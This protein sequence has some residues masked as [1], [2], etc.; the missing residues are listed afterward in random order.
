MTITTQSSAQVGSYSLNICG[1]DGT[2]NRCV[3]Y[4][5]N[6]TALGSVIN[7]PQ[8]LTLDATN[9]ATTSATFNG[10]LTSL[11]YD[12]VICPSCSCIV[13]FDW[14]TS[15]GVYTASTSLQTKTSTGAFSAD[16]SGLDPN[17]YY[18]FKARAKN[19]GGW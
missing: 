1:T 9:I 18:Y 6:I 3:T 8:V 16:I 11:G 2:T 14:G 12:P 19:G 4:G 13:W 15:T 10:N 17:S 7:P 5:L